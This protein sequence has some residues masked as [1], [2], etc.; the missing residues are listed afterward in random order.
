ML[1]EAVGSYSRRQSKASE[2]RP[3]GRD[4]IAATPNP[5]LPRAAR[6]RMKERVICRKAKTVLLVH[7]ARC[8]ILGSLRDGFHQMGIDH[9]ILGGIP[10]DAHR[11]QALLHS[12]Y[13]SHHHFP[14][15]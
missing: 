9:R 2:S 10:D 15:H 3:V 14:Q 12:L 7:G 8:T 1:K 13:L 4:Y 5:F 11:L 6:E